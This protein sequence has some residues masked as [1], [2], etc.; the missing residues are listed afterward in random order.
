MIATAPPRRSP[1][2]R[3]A[4]LTLYDALVGIAVLGLGLGTVL[5][6]LAGMGQRQVFNES[7]ISGSMVAQAVM[8]RALVK[9]FAS[10]DTLAGTGLTYDA[11]YYPNY[12]YDLNVV[13]VN[14]TNL[15][16]A[17]GGPTSY[18]RV[19]VQVYHTLRGAA[20]KRAELRAILISGA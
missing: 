15:D 17:V 4:G 5:T 9:G 10:V 20:I 13:Y 16:T 18:K 19:E 3:R 2:R 11:T 1:R 7:M 14:V 8:E 6:S 12:T